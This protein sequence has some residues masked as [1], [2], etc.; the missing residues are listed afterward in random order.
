MTL[1]LAPVPNEA[2]SFVLVSG[3]VTIGVL[4]LEPGE[5]GGD[6]WCFSIYALHLET[7]GIER[8]GAAAT[9]ADA[10][11]IAERRWG[12]I[13]AALGLRPA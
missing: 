7:L 13:L 4:R 6:L 1:R 12:E 11:G 3:E 8:I 10:L 9:M 2:D 5:A